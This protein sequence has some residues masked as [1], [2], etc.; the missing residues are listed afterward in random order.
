MP[1]MKIS[2]SAILSVSAPEMR[3]LIAAELASREFPAR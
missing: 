1:F 2:R 3:L